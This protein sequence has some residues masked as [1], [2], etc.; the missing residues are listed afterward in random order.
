MAEHCPFGKLRAKTISL[1]DREITC[2]GGALPFDRLRA[3]V[4]LLP[5][6]VS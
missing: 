4:W 6:L 5:A 2:F 1:R 3:N